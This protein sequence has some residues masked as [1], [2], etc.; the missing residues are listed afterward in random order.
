MPYDGRAIR[1]KLHD[2]FTSGISTKECQAML[3]DD[4]S[5]ELQGGLGIWA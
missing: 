5:Q 4:P 2:G 3:K 1:G